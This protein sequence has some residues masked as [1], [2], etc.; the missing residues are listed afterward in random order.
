MLEVFTEFEGNEFV[1]EKLPPGSILNYRTLHMEDKMA[2]NIRASTGT[3]LRMLRNDKIEILKEM[4]D[5]FSKKMSL[6]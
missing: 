6:W 4:D 1:I 5:N 2:V 3:Y